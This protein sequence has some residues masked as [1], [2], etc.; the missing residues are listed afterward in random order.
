MSRSF[1]LRRNDDG[2]AAVEFAIAVPV[3]VSFL[4]GFFT[5]GLLYQANAGLQHALGEAARF[6]TL[7]IEANDGPP[8]DSEIEARIAATDFGLSGGTLETPQIDN[9]AI[10]DGYKT[11]TLTYSRPTDFLFFPGP[12]VTVTRSKRVYIASPA[13]A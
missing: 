9:S 10:A 1:K 13:T 3:L 12:T 6:A 7:Y 11:I 8:S 4:Y 5:L 2:S